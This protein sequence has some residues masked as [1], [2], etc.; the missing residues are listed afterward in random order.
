M[1]F[2]EG[3]SWYN[4]LVEFCSLTGFLSLVVLLKYLILRILNI[5]VWQKLHIRNVSYEISQTQDC[6]IAVYSFV[7]FLV[8]R[9]TLSVIFLCSDNSP[10]PGL[11]TGPLVLPSCQSVAVSY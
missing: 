2:F 3:S 5:E 8:E 1:I 4:I 10:R 9:E 11:V 6:P 7:N